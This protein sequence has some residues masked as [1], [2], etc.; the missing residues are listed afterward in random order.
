MIGTLITIAL[1]GTIVGVA[2][3]GS[4]Q[5][6]VDFLKGVYEK[7]KEVV[8]KIVAGVKCFLKKAWDTIT[9]IVK[10]YF[11][12]RENDKWTVRT[13]ER[14]IP[15]EDVESEVPEDIRARVQREQ[16]R[17]HDVTESV[18]LKLKECA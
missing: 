8:S 17:E 1:I 9:E 13:S 11:Y 2:V 4:W 10:A 6:F 18:E 5:N 3:Y 15:P 12:D 16:Y 7:V 14:D